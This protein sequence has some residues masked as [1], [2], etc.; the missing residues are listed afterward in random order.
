MTISS[1]LNLLPHTQTTSPAETSGSANTLQEQ[2]EPNNSA[3]NNA[4][5]VR[6][7]D[8]V[9]LST[10]AGII[11]SLAGTST[12]ASNSYNAKGLLDTYYGAKQSNALNNPILQSDSS[13]AI[14]AIQGSVIDNILPAAL[15]SINT[16]AKSSTT[17]SSTTP[18][19]T[20]AAKSNSGHT[21]KTVDVNSAWAKVLQTQPDLASDLG[22]SLMDQNIIDTL[23]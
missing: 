3:N 18:S 8:T 11:N 16:P 10:N 21:T 1:L 20:G 5:D 15:A 19:K 17:A 4:A 7:H 22:D 23:A 2:Q 9:S 14:D 12:Q 13:S 6:V